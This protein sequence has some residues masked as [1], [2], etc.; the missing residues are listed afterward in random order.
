MEISTNLRYERQ[1]YGHRNL[2][3]TSKCIT[4]VIPAKTP[5]TNQEKEP[6]DEQFSGFYTRE[7]DVILVIEG[8]M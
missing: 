7:K 4:Y 2:N 5:K 3:T 8:R 1:N 6:S